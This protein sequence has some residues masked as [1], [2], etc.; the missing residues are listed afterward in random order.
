MQ[1][2]AQQLFKDLEAGIRKPFYVIVGEEPFQMSEILSRLKK[3]FLAKEEDGTFNF[4]AFDGEHLD[5]S[6][7]IGSLD[8]LPGL[9]DGPGAMRLILCR[10]F[11]KIN[12][13][14]IEA[15]DRYFKSPS[16]TTCFVIQAGKMDKRKAWVK[17]VDAKGDVVE[18]SEPYDR[19]WPK[20]QGY[21]E[22]KIEKKIDGEM[23]KEDLFNCIERGRFLSGSTSNQNPLPSY[24]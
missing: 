17:A 21:F 18:V 1:I 22:R 14:G 8:T 4:E 10:H 9:F 5:V 2:T 7:L 19:E 11:E 23:C 3:V 20:W 6:A 24:P 12:A 13:T 15:L 16:D